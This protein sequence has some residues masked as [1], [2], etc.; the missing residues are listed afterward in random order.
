MSET[1]QGLCPKTPF[2]EGTGSALTSGTIFL[3]SQPDPNGHLVTQGQW[4]QNGLLWS[5]RKGTE[6]TSLTP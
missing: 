3:E 4:G 6:D 5:W 2:P 1:I